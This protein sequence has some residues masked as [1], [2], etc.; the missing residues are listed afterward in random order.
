M[1][2]S[3]TLV[4]APC[5][6]IEIARGI[7]DSCTVAGRDACGIKTEG[8]EMRLQHDD[9]STRVEH[10]TGRALSRS[11]EVFPASNAKLTRRAMF[12]FAAQLAPGLLM[13][14]RDDSSTLLPPRSSKD[15]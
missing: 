15:V 5:H 6:G 9:L 13:A 3:V 11:L 8:A 7:G 12:R 10:S 4:M 14:P 1:H 2:V